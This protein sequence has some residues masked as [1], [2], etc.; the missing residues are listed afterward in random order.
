LVELL[1]VVA[2]IGLLVGL[3]LPAVQQVRTEAWR[4]SSLNNLKQIGLALQ[5]YEGTWRRFPPGYLSDGFHP[6]ADPATLDGP[7]GWAWGTW[8]L[9]YVEAQAVHDQLNLA[10]PCNDPVN[11][12]YVTSQIPVFINPGA[13]NA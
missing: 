5:H 3:L 4:T 9:P 11:L 6:A 7:P 1:V 2:V 12:P 13:L 10:L 8:L